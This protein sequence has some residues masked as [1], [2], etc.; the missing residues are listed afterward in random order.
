[1]KVSF[2]S[3]T[4]IEY[5]DKRHHLRSNFIRE[6]RKI[7][8][9]PSGSANT[10]TRWWMYSDVMELLLPH[11]TPRLTSSNV[12]T[13]PDKDCRE[14]KDT[15]RNSSPSTAIE[16]PDN[17]FPQETAHF[18]EIC[19]DHSTIKASLPICKKPS[20]VKLMD[21]FDVRFIQQRTPC[22]GRRWYSG[23]AFW[24]TS[25]GSRV[26]IPVIR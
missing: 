19:E 12:T 14:T 21:C 1:M 15:P 11:V 13:F 26:Q 2:N 10:Q 4:E 5:K 23:L 3:F 8:A 9:K 17:T 22:G 16:A 24:Y 6:K 20:V 25:L 18:N 7:S